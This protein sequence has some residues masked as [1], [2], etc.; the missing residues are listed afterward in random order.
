MMNFKGSS[1][2]LEIMLRCISDNNKQAT[3]KKLTQ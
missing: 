3:K 1:K 2:M